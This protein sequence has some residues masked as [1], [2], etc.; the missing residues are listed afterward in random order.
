MSQTL[1]QVHFCSF[2]GRTS[3]LKATALLFAILRF[4]WLQT[5]GTK[6]LAELILFQL[7]LDSFQVFFNSMCTY[8]PPAPIRCIC[9]L[10]EGIEQEPKPVGNA[11]IGSLWKASKCKRSTH[12][13]HSHKCP[14]RIMPSSTSTRNI[15]NP[16]SICGKFMQ[17]KMPAETIRKQSNQEKYTSATLQ[18]YQLLWTNACYPLLVC[19]NQFSKSVQI[20][21]LGN[22]DCG[23]VDVGS[24]LFLWY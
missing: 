19:K 13:T 17:K 18:Q 3:R 16:E 23:L 22:G 2:A 9:Q 8:L 7:F 6:A 20:S 5:N 24:S 10:C 15:K 1:P 14:K 21:D 12:L 4:K 11:P